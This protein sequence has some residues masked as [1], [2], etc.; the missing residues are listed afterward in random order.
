[1]PSKLT[2]PG[3]GGPVPKELPKGSLLGDWPGDDDTFRTSKNQAFN[4]DS[5]ANQQKAPLLPKPQ[6]GTNQNMPITDLNKFYNYQSAVDIA[7]QSTLDAPSAGDDQSTPVLK[8]GVAKK[9]DLSAFYNYEEDPPV[10]PPMPMKT[11]RKR[12]GATSF[13]NASMGKGSNRKGPNPGFKN[14][15]NKQSQGFRNS[16]KGE[17]FGNTS[18]GQSYTNDGNQGLGFGLNIREEEFHNSQGQEYSNVS[19]DQ[20]NLGLG[21][22]SDMYNEEVAQPTG[23]HNTEEGYGENQLQEGFNQGRRK[24]S[25]KQDKFSDFRNQGNNTY[26]RNSTQF[27]AHRS[28]SGMDNSFNSAFDQDSAAAVDASGFH[29]NGKPER[30][31]RGSWSGSQPV[32]R[33]FNEGPGE[34]TSPGDGDWNRGPGFKSRGGRGRGSSNASG[35]AGRRGGRGGGGSSSGRGGGHGS[36]GSVGGHRGGRG[37]RSRGRPG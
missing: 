21:Q 9:P 35:V 29:G 18:Q 30:D 24:T 10:T 32:K 1:M 19:Q 5:F 23:F 26:N 36:G 33:G 37:Q 7:N 6:Q 25:Y 22:T 2:L 17:G 11:D 14:T 27:N 16:N 28:D 20:G 8:T 13:K 31:T 4:F 12:Q 34:D 15:K 3:L